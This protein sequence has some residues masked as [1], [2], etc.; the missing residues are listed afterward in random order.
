MDVEHTTTTPHFPQ[1]NGQVENFNRTMGHY[2]RT[3]LADSSTEKTDWELMLGPLMFSHNT[4]VHKATRMTPFY[5]MFGYDPRAPLWP[6]MSVLEEQDFGVKK[7]NERQLFQDFHYR[8][9]VARKITHDNNLAA[10][11][12]RDR[13][14]P[15]P[16]SCHYAMGERVW[17][18]IFK[19]G[20]EKNSK[21]HPNWEKA[22][23]IGA[24]GHGA[25]KIQKFKGR[26][27]TKTVNTKYIRRD[28][29]LEE[30]GDSDD[31]ENPD[32]TEEAGV[33]TMDENKEIWASNMDGWTWGDLRKLF[34]VNQEWKQMTRFASLC[35][36]AEDLPD[37][38]QNENQIPQALRNL[39]IGAGTPEAKREPFARDVIRR[40]MAEGEERRQQN[41]LAQNRKLKAEQDEFWGEGEFDKKNKQKRQADARRRQ[42]EEEQFV[43]DDDD[44]D[45]DEENQQE[46][47]TRKEREKEEDEITR[48]ALEGTGAKKKTIPRQSNWKTLTMK[49]KKTAVEAPAPTPA[50]R[51]RSHP[52]SPPP[53]TDDKHR[54][55]TGGKKK[56]LT[57]PL[58]QFEAFKLRRQQSARREMDFSARPN[59]DDDELEKEEREKREKEKKKKKDGPSKP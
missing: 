51:T 32:E 58:A 6:E 15:N 23:I 53:P 19:T 18:R 33:E 56:V 34:Q 43:H 17:V 50:T 7:A 40:Q 9:L 3:M 11:A 20:T 8:Q 14:P 22:I 46:E 36:R 42:A 37:W 28:K 39:I 16:E 29:A 10:T 5:S 4:A 24:T 13:L 45:D 25:Y 55:L 26:R 47:R 54:L 49:E 2:L 48:K 30:P 57:S 38:P 1:C 31:E 27:K 12:Q 35:G 41:I 21:L 59:D 44:D 52:Y